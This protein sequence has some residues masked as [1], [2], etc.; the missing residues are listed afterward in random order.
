M[1][2]L[3]LIP[4]T[5][6]EAYAYHTYEENG[7]ILN[8]LIRIEKG[9][10]DWIEKSELLASIPGAQIHNGGRVKIGPDEKLYVTAGDVANPDSAQDLDILSG[11]I[12]R[13]EQDGSI[14]E[15]NP[16]TN[17]LVYSYG[18][19]NPQGIAWDEKEQMYATEHGQSAH[20]EIN[21][22][23]PGKNYG[24]PDI[25][26]DEKKAGM[27]TPIFQTNGNTW[28]PSGTAYHNGK[29]Y[30]ATLRGEAVRVY[31]LINNVPSILTE[32]N[33]RIRDVLIENDILYFI[34]NNTDGRGTPSENDD[35]LLS[36]ELK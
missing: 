8:R 19:R 36:V 27:I 22:I 10:D 23:E 9:R 24:W 20:D 28:A 18:H 15:D 2:G 1:L 34:T 17:S 12:L 6:L 3:E 14:P 16:F 26:G 33:G 29:L 5:D 13:L 25:Q 30:I 4:E 31:D 11:K 7:K 21:K 35:R 32:G